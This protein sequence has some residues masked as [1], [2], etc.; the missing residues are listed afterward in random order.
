MPYVEI[1][2]NIY[3]L[4]GKANVGNYGYL[5][6]T[7]ERN[8]GVI[9]T[10]AREFWEETKQLIPV[11][12]LKRRLKYSLDVDVLRKVYKNITYYF[13]VMPWKSLC[14]MHPRKFVESWHRQQ[15]PGDRFNEK[16]DIKLVHIDD[17]DQMTRTVRMIIK[18]VK[19]LILFQQNFK[20]FLNYHQNYDFTAMIAS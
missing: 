6:G 10:A 2:D 1:D 19:N 15:I 3:L 20:D 4:L 18:R 17:Q 13:F 8:E 5:G 12:E 9:Q 11:R 16:I 7:Q 14:D